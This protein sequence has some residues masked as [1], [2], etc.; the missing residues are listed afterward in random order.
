MKNDLDTITCADKKDAENMIDIIGGEHI[1]DWEF[2]DGGPVKLILNCKLED[3]AND[4]KG[5]TRNKHDAL[6][7]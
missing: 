2:L 3:I 1:K 6:R 5:I 7:C 4:S